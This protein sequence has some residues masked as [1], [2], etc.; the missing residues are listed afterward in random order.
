MATTV[1]GRLRGWLHAH[2]TW[3]IEHDYPNVAHYVP[4]L[5]SQ[6]RS[7]RG[8]SPLLHLGRCWA[9]SLRR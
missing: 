7:G 2:L 9:C 3:M 6:P 8:K 4:D 5:M 1:L